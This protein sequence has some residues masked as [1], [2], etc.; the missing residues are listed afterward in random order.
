MKKINQLLFISCLTLG[1]S[2]CGG[3]SSKDDGDDKSSKISGL[4]ECV[5]PNA[6]QAVICGTALASDKVTP[7]INAKISLASGRSVSTLAKGVENPDECRTG[8]D[9]GFSCALPEGTKGTVNLI[10]S[11]DGFDN[12]NFTMEATPGV[13]TEYDG[14]LSLVS[15]TNNKWV[16]I[17][18]NYDGVQVLL[19]QLKGCTLN[20]ADGLPQYAT[21]SDDCVNKGLLVLD[22]SDDAIEGF[23]GTKELLNYGYLFVNCGQESKYSNTATNSL[24]KSFV[25]NGGHAYFSD[26][27]SSWL[28]DA[29]PEKVNFLGNNTQV[30]TVNADV[31]TPGLQSVVGSNMNIKFDL[32]VWSA[33]DDVASDVTTFVEGDFS[34]F[35]GYTGTHPITVGW[36][37]ETNSGCVFYSS[38]HIE[39]ASEG[40]AQE[41]AT[42]YLVQNISSVCQ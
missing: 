9:G 24:L 25:D 35:S 16:V 12:Q 20:N 4:A 32:P 8:S 31:L 11:L 26:L 14:E 34:S 3:G 23:L 7:L 37:E 15:N 41:R 19:A 2:A 18:G 28:T 13:A 27:A 33:I 22:D 42:K 38:Y 30:G 1:V 21:G 39:G 29:F 10:V 40:A 6:T 36:K 5:A 17:P